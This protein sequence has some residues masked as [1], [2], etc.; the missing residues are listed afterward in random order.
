MLIQQKKQI[1]SI[2]KLKRLTFGKVKCCSSVAAG[3]NKDS[4]TRPLV[5]Y[6][7]EQISYGA[8]ANSIFVSLCLNYD[9][10]SKYGARIECDAVDS[11]ITRGS[12]LASVQPH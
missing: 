6:R 10:S 5:L 2:K 3:G 1:P 9:L 11:A 7:A 8:H 12:C 4:F